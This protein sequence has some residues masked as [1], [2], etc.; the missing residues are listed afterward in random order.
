MS[1]SEPRFFALIIGT[2]ILNRR[3]VDK[4]FDF[5][6]TALQAKRIQTFRLFHHRR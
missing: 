3:R 4:H 2:E 6:T 5:V 1:I